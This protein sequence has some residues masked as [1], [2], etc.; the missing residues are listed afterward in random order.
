[1]CRK[2]ICMD[3]THLARRQW[4]VHTSRRFWVDEGGGRAAARV[5]ELGVYGDMYVR[6]GG[7][8][9]AVGR[10]LVGKWEVECWR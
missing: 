6:V 4:S 10:W 2:W 8:R 5:G 7:T 3:V 1:M 9:V